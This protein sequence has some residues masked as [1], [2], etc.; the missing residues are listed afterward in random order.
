MNRHF[1]TNAAVAALTL[2]SCAPLERGM[3]A[4]S[5]I[6]AQVDG[7]KLTVD[8]AASI[9]TV[10]NPSTVP[11]RPSTVYRLSE[12]WIGYTVLADELAGR[13][14]LATETV[15]ALARFSR[16]QELVW[17][18]QE[19]V[20][21]NRVEPQTEQLRASYRREQPFTKVEAQ[22][23]L[24][25]V[26]GNADAAT[27]DSLRARAEQIRQR[28]LDGEDFGE[29]ARRFSDDPSSAG[30]GGSLGYVERGQLV[31]EVE[32]AIFALEPGEISETVRSTYGYHII[33]ATDRQVPEF[34]EVSDSYRARFLQGR[35]RNLERAYI[36]SLFEAADLRFMRGFVP[37][38][39][40]NSITSR[41]GHLTP[42]ERAGQLVRYDGG[43]LTVG[44]WADFV[45][46]G[47]QDMRT[48][49]ASRDSAGVASLLREMVR[50]ELL[51]KAAH[52]HELE[53]DETVRDSLLAAAQRDVQGAILASGLRRHLNTE[54]VSPQLAVDR[55]LVELITQQ[56]GPRPIERLLPALLEGR[57]VRVHPERFRE[58]LRR[59]AELREQAPQG[60]PAPDV[61]PKV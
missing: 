21:V 4:H 15:E 37:L 14:S 2:A 6:V 22:H 42:M 53:L 49:F 17:R 61:A 3:E 59:L 58:V 5:D 28:A 52:D 54:G 56:R 7:Y 48:A 50:N 43:A 46:R 26:P 38:V 40:Q 35:L 34:E 1:V 36:D 13:D 9:L 27:L 39:K 8:H 33:R 25:R 18:L 20:I 60:Q 19:E 41:L 32:N 47:G 44:E 10:G 31:P 55:S 45:I 16:D 12:L 11:L 23:I 24:I 57:A 30:R 51:I 29:L